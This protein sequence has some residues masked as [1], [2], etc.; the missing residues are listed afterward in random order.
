MVQFQRRSGEP[1]GGVHKVTF[2]GSRNVCVLYILLSDLWCERR[3]LGRAARRGGRFFFVDGARVHD[4]GY[5][6]LRGFRHRA[7]ADL[8][9]VDAVLEQRI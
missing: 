6:R 2:G 4:G 1:C 9:L 3:V 8:L 7:A 5:H